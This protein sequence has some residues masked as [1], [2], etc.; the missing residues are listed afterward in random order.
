[1]P[2]SVAYL[3][4]AAKKTMCLRDSRKILEYSI[5]SI[6]FSFLVPNFLYNKWDLKNINSEQFVEFLR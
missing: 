4:N 5:F 2:S 6:T 1:M 3:I